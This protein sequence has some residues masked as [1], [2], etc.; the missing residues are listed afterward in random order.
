MKKNKV[1]EH[2]FSSLLPSYKENF[3]QKNS[4]KSHQF[5]TR[6]SLVR[7]LLDRANGNL[8]DCACG[9]GEITASVLNSGDFSNVVVSDISK[10]MLISARNLISKNNNIENIIFQNVDIFE[11][12]KTTGQKFDV[13]LCLGLIAHTGRLEDLI[14]HLKSMLSTKGVILLQS[15]LVEHWGVKFERFIGAKS[16]T[17]KHG[18]EI[19]YYT[20]SAIERVVKSSGMKIVKSKKYCFGFPF[21]DRIFGI[22]NYWLE[23][24]S[25]RFSSKKGSECIFVLQGR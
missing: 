24:F 13:I 22:G 11:Y 8:F 25:K 17:R 5:R 15:S 12:K 7:S 1:V 2:H 16:F 14:R 23:K 10:E 19:S 4:G 21:G 18:Y 9:T 3:S 6:L 20:V